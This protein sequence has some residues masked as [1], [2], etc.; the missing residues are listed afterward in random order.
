MQIYPIKTEDHLNYRCKDR[1]I[2][3]FGLESVK[4]KL[5]YVRLK[6][7]SDRC[8]NLSLTPKEVGRII[9]TYDVLQ[10]INLGAAN[11]PGERLECRT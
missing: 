5:S 7:L 2:Y 8:K 4:T 10:L 6:C 1:K 11:M 9:P 3:T